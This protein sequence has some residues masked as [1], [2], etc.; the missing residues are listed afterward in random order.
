[1]FHAFVVT[2]MVNF[3]AFLKKEHKNDKLTTYTYK[4]RGWKWKQRKIHNTM[5]TINIRN[6][7]N[8]GVS[9][10]ICPQNSAGIAINRTKLI[11]MLDN[12]FKC[13][14]VCDCVMTLNCATILTAWCLV[15]CC[16]SL[17][18]SFV[19]FFFCWTHNYLCN[20]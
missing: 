18:L 20:K 2:F 10:I 13:I 11:A 15:L 17:S 16:F 6:A 9:C 19:S 5:A 3:D 4:Y 14:L 8:K 1:M 12:W 7:T